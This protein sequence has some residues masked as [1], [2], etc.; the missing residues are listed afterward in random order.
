MGKL[1]YVQ[2]KMGLQFGHSGTFLHP[3]HNAARAA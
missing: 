2:V 3:K 1:H